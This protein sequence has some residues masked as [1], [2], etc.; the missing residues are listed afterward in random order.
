MFH[1]CSYLTQYM[2]SKCFVFPVLFSSSPLPPQFL[3]PFDKLLAAQDSPLWHPIQVC[4]F[5]PG[6]S[7]PDPSFTLSVLRFKG[8]YLDWPSFQQ[9]SDLCQDKELLTYGEVIMVV[10][11]LASNG[12][13][14]LPFRGHFCNLREPL[15]LQY[16]VI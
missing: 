6:S 16:S 14:M 5:L 10:Y 12:L 13:Q 9:G 15:E 2:I 1:L 3:V 7:T 8:I 11:Q 4:L